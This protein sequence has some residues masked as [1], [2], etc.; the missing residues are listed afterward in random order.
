MLAS[1]LTEPILVSNIR[2]NCRTSVQ[3]RVP[4]M[5]QTISQSSMSF[6]TSARLLSSSDFTMR[7]VAVF[8]FSA[9]SST[10]W[11]VLRNISSSKLSPKRFFAFS[12]SLLIFSSCFATQSSI[13]TSARYRFLLSLLSIM[14]SL[15][16]PTCP[17]ATHV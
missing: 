2:L 9:T 6:L 10:L 5:G 16:D 7:A 3:L 1:S 17:D 13:R 11:L 12:T 14:G 4:E 15:N 8:I